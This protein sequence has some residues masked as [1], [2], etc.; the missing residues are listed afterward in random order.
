MDAEKSEEVVETYGGKERVW[1]GK[2]GL[3]GME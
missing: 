1:S 2:Q 3:D